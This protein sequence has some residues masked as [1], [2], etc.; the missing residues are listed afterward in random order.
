MTCTADQ[1]L[2][3]NGS[4][5]A[6]NLACTYLLNRGDRRYGWNTSA[7]LARAG[8][9]LE[10]NGAQLVPVPIDGDG[11]RVDDGMMRAPGRVDGICDAIVPISAGGYDVTPAEVGVVG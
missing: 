2:I 3:V 8:N 11:M 1:V 5:Q 9:A 7:I 4:Q 6:L 10:N